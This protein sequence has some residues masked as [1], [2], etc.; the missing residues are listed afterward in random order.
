MNSQ[1]DR[2]IASVKSPG[3]QEIIGLTYPG[4]SPC[5]RW[6]EQNVD[7]GWRYQGE[8]V[9]EF[10]RRQDYLMFVLRWS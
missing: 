1:Q 3:L 2:Y 9:F 4:W 7:D 10:N 6:C 5:I 8:G